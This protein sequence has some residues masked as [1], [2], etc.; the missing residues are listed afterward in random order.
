MT[1]E[2]GDSQSSVVVKVASVPKKK[3]NAES[4]DRALAAFHSSDV[5]PRRRRGSKTLVCF[6]QSKKQ[7]SNEAARG[8]ERGAKCPL[9]VEPRGKRQKK[10]KQQIFLSLSLSRSTWSPRLLHPAT[11]YLRTEFTRR[12]EERHSPVERAFGRRSHGEKRALL[13]DVAGPRNEEQ[14]PTR[15]LDGGLARKREDSLSLSWLVP[16]A[17]KQETPR[18]KGLLGD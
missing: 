13:L 6:H 8:G 14:P 2:G 15:K 4:S 9:E 3:K 1:R 17:K 5:S 12:P 7:G 18:N 16:T 10:K 11:P